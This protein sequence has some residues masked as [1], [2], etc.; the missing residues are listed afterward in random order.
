MTIFT[1]RRVL[2]DMI[3]NHIDFQH[4]IY[5]ICPKCNPRH[6][7]TCL[8]C[9]WR[10][11]M[12]TCDVGVG[13][14]PD[15]SYNEGELQIVKRIFSQQ[16]QFVV[17]KYWNVQYFPTKEAAEKALKEYDEIRN[18]S[19]IPLRIR[20]YDLWETKRREKFEAVPLV[21]PFEWEGEE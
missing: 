3:A 6:N 4:P 19:F 2:D 5:K 8:N 17:C 15:G 16:M 11:T 12:N 14:Y 20:A 7:G 18:C 1:V 10:G 9:A 21:K 13:V